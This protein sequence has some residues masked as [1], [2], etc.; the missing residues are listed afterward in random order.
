MC[1]IPG[2]G[3]PFVEVG[4]VSDLDADVWEG[5]AVVEVASFLFLEELDE[6]LFVEPGL[7]GDVGVAFFVPVEELECVLVLVFRVVTVV[8][9]EDVDNVLG[10]VF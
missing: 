2:V 10:F 3:D 5:V 1:P 9:E 4:I 6:D 7:Y 8:V